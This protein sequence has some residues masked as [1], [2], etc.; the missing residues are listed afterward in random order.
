MDVL[1]SCKEI[2]LSGVWCVVSGGVFFTPLRRRRDSPKAGLF[3]RPQTPQSRFVLAASC[4]GV[5][6]RVRRST[7]DR[8]QAVQQLDK[9]RQRKRKLKATYIWQIATKWG[10]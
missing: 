2:S 5:G 10:R 3:W 6:V 4:V 7:S 9:G 8:Q 1:D